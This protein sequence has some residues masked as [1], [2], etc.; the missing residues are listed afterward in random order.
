[1]ELALSTSRAVEEELVLVPI[2]DPVGA[3]AVSIIRQPHAATLL[4]CRE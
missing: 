3:P 2:V 1:V 4:T